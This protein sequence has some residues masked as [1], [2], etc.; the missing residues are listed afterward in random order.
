MLAVGAVVGFGVSL[1]I[2]RSHSAPDPIVITPAPSGPVSVPPATEK[3]KSE[4]V[5]QVAGEVKAPGVFHLPT[6]ARVQDALHAAGGP[7][8]NAN[9]DPFNLAAIL[10]DGTQLRIPKQLIASSKANPETKLP[11]MRGQI[12]PV[13]VTIPPEYQVTPVANSTYS[14]TSKPNQNSSGTHRSGAKKTPTE[15]ISLNSA[16][17]EQLQMLPGVGPSTADKIIAYRQTHGGF[18]SVDE[19]LD[20]KGIGPKKLEKMRPWLRL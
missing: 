7:T 14:A 1:T 13:S 11:R 3:A 17:A 6:G 4:V 15:P 10:V 16:T 12:A 5:V 20:V 2:N 8:S 18:T 19:M 9:L